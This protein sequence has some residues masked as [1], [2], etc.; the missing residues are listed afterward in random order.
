MEEE[1]E[2]NDLEAMMAEE[3]AA[4]EGEE[5]DDGGEEQKYAHDEGR[6][7]LVLAQVEV[8]DVLT[9]LDQGELDL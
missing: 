4:E 7:V 3:D 2:E 8:L 9:V 6:G 5:E 1:V